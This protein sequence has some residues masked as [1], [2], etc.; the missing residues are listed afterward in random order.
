MFF[1][2]LLD[3]ECNAQINLVS[4][5]SFEDTIDC[6]GS[7]GIT[8]P[9]TVNHYVKNWVTYKNMT[10]DYYNSCANNYSGGSYPN[11]ASVPYNDFGYQLPHIGKGF[12]GIA[13]YAIF[14]TFDS[15]NIYTEQLVIKLNQALKSNRCYY[16][17]F[18][19]NSSNMSTIIVNRIGM[20]LSQ[21]T[22]TLAPY[23]FN[24]TIQPQIQWD[25]TQFFSDTLN[26]VK[27]SGSFTAQ[28]DEEYLSIGNFRDG[29]HVKKQFITNNFIPPFAPPNPNFGS[30]VYIDDVSLYE[31]PQ[32]TTGTSNYAVC[33][34]SDSLLLG[35]VPYPGS[36][37]QWFVN[38]VPISAQS[39]IKV[40]PNATTN[41]V[42]QTNACSTSTQTFAVTYNNI[43]PPTDTVLI[44]PNA[45]TP[46]NDSVN[47]VFRF[48]VSNVKE[49]LS[50][51]VYNRWGNLIC[52]NNGS[53]LV[54]NAYSQVTI[55]WDGRT[56]S[57]EPCIEGV[58]FYTLKY[59]NTN[60]EQQSRN[61][62]L[63]LFR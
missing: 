31:L 40:K 37:Y 34:E 30:Y 57:G 2:I 56:T 16:G 51:A 27:V 53:A 9:I 15:V 10:P 55:L 46:N 45:F 14:N 8:N 43:C 50:F 61:G 22:N 28:G 17:E 18:Y 59:T 58:Y 11:G 3:R 39:Q 32:T 47:D 52:N 20:L 6:F 24:N 42:L 5:P 12:P 21:T 54:P 19:V 63:S 13:L 36:T 4:N 41:Y 62:Y 49:N 25:T 29:A 7:M 38:G 1:S 23:I 33:M 35:E 48:I 26:W 60:G 44:I